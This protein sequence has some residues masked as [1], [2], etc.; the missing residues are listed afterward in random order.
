MPRNAKGQ[1]EPGTCGNPGGR[2]CKSR[3][4]IS[5][6]QL[7]ESF[8]EAG[9]TMVSIVENGRRKSIPARLAIEKQ[10]AIRAA[11]GDMRAIVEWNKRNERHTSEHAKRRLELLDC[12]IKSEDNIRKHPEDVTDEYKA[13]T[14]QLRAILEPDLFD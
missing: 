6:E 14:A 9:E 2:P 8:F 4:K 11:S 10:L 7:R 12:L 1:F 13:L 3:R 5:E